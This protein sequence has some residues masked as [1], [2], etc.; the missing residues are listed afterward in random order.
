M[1]SLLQVSDTALDT[2]SLSQKNICDEII[3]KITAFQARKGEWITSNCSHI[4]DGDVHYWGIHKSQQMQAQD[5]VESILLTHQLYQEIKSHI[6][7]KMNLPSDAKV[8]QVVGGS[9]SFSKEGTE[10]SK[11]FLRSQLKEDCLVSYGYTGIVESNGSAC[12]NACVSDIIFEKNMQGRTV[13]N[14]VGFSY[15]YSLKAV[16]I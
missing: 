5:G 13:A 6:L 10:R 9:S 7:Q 11:D 8:I 4:Q 16:E 2:T 15:T 12:V 14:L 1:E 3:P